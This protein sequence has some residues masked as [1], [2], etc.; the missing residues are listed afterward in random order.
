LVGALLG[1]AA[2]QAAQPAERYRVRILQSSLLHRRAPYLRL[3]C[4]SEQV[5]GSISY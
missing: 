5:L 4:F 1:F 3:L 2:Y